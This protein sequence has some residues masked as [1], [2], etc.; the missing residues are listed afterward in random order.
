MSTVD[1]TSLNCK[2]TMIDNRLKVVKFGEKKDFNCLNILSNPGKHIN[3][4]CNF[5]VQV[6][7]VWFKLFL[8]E[9]TG[10]GPPS[11]LIV[12]GSR[13]RRLPK[14]FEVN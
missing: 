14:I 4:Y 12:K 8:Y 5:L 6:N 10:S 2:V 9:T 13:L 1:V 7:S 11:M 3:F